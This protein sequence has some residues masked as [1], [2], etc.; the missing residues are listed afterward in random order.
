VDGSTER[1]YIEI[2]AAETRHRTIVPAEYP[3]LALLAWN[4]DPARPI[5]AAEAFALYE[6]NWRHVDPSRLTLHEAE[7][8]R[9]LIHDFGNGHWLAA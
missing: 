3:E 1:D 6:R 9:E 7:L 4:R 5:D 8:I 2:M